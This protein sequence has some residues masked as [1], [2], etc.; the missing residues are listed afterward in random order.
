MATGTDARGVVVVGGAGVGPSAFQ[1]SQLAFIWDGVN[2][3][4]RLIGEVLGDTLPLGWRLISAQGI[5]ENG[6][7]VIGNGVSPTNQGRPWMAVLGEA[8]GNE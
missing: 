3:Q 6:R 2:D 5:S 7:V 8:C 4:I 1:D